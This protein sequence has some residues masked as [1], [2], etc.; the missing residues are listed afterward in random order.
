MSILLP[1]KQLFA[2]VY[3]FDC[4]YYVF[5]GIVNYL[6][7]QIIMERKFIGAMF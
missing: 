3:A 5:S 6:Q 1:E 2:L 4:F 7:G